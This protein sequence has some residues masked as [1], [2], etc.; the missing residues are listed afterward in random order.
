MHSLIHSLYIASHTQFNNSYRCRENCTIHVYEVDRIEVLQQGQSYN[1]NRA[2]LILY[3]MEV[4]ILW[5]FI[6]WQSFLFSLLKE[7]EGILRSFEI[8]LYSRGRKLKP[9]MPPTRAKTD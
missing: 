1:D 6:I 4:R 8:L 5:H 2:S 7:V 3:R 9:F